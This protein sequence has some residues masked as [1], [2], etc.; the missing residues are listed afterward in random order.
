MR[1]SRSSTRRLIARRSIIR[2]RLLNLLKLLN[3]RSQDHALAALATLAGTA[4]PRAI[5][6]APRIGVAISRN[7][8]PSASMT[9]AR[10]R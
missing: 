3:P 8:L 4:R 5:L 2:R 6:G 10:E 7:V 1:A 9:V